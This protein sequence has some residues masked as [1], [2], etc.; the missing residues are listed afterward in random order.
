[1]VASL[2]LLFLSLFTSVMK[3]KSGGKKRRPIMD[4]VS[5][6]SARIQC[7]RNNRPGT[8][9]ASP[10][11][12]ATTREF[13]K[14][15][16]KTILPHYILSPSLSVIHSLRAVTMLDLLFLLV[17]LINAIGLTEIS[18]RLFPESSV[19]AVRAFSAT[20]NIQ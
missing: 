19:E 17:R 5:R 18:S 2:L 20:L 11:L 9:T 10:L 16:R 13:R 8:R 1:M 6:P 3:C 14:R 4:A 7:R 15:R 12:M